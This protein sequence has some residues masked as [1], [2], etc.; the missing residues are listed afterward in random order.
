MSR[1]SHPTH[2]MHSSPLFTL[3]TVLEGFQICPNQ[4]SF[5]GIAKA[6]LELLLFRIFA[7]FGKPLH[8]SGEQN[9]LPVQ[10]EIGGVN[11]KGRKK[12]LIVF[13]TWLPSLSKKRRLVP[14]TV[15]HRTN[16]N[17]HAKVFE[18]GIHLKVSTLQRLRQD[19]T[20]MRGGIGIR[21]RAVEAEDAA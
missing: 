7:D 10:I 6:D 17:M 5:R 21:M 3:I 20:E 19:I 14:S 13:F 12:L 11:G 2:F 4:V 16:P 15:E 8:A 1:F 9:E 18:E